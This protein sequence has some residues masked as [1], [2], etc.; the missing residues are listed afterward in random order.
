MARTSSPFDRFH[1]T[2]AGGVT[3]VTPSGEMAVKWAGLFA[4]VAAFIWVFALGMYVWQVSNPL[5]GVFSGIVGALGGLLAACAWVT[6]RRRKRPLTVGPDR[7]VRYGRRVWFNGQIYAVGL[8]REVTNSEGEDVI[9][10]DLFLRTDRKRLPLPWPYFRV[11]YDATEARQ[12]ATMLAAALG[13]P[14][15]EH[16]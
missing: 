15:E 7:V 12:V 11:I 9:S 5:I 4:L 2:T 10:Y 14:V 8:V 1:V 6:W 13:V 16:G 3:T